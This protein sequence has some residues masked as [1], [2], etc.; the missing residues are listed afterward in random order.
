MARLSDEDRLRDVRAPLM[1]WNA[2]KIV[3]LNGVPVDPLEYAETFKA[4][5]HV[6]IE[7]TIRRGQSAFGPIDPPTLLERL[8]VYDW[9]DAIVA[10]GMAIMMTGAGLLCA[11]LAW[12]LVMP[13]N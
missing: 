13:T 5:T 8:S 1:D 12:R 10:V 11:A 7:E 3:R 6:S 9:Q 4:P 2:E